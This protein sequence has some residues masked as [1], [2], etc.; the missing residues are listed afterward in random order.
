VQGY[1][2][3]SAGAGRRHRPRPSAAAITSRAIGA[4]TARPGR[5]VRQAAAVQHDDADGD[6][7][8][9]RTA[10]RSTSPHHLAI[11][12]RRWETRRTFKTARTTAAYTAKL[13]APQATTSHA[14]CHTPLPGAPSASWGGSALGPTTASY[15]ASS[16]DTSWRPTRTLPTPRPSDST[17]CSWVGPRIPT[18]GVTTIPNST[19]VSC[20]WSPCRDR[21]RSRPGATT[22]KRRLPGLVLRPV[23][24]PH[25]DAKI[26]FRRSPSGCASFLSCDRPIGSGVQMQPE[27]QSALSGDAVK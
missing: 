25:S 16:L 21:L 23:H 10:P 19:V 12:G 7:R 26:G 6:L 11:V 5:L 24:A 27:R 15:S 20:S 22:S 14:L 2:L 18:S 4:A 17:R 3:G 9:Q 1:R 13:Q 8:R